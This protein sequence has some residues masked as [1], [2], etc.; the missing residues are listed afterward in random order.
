MFRAKNGTMIFVG[1]STGYIRVFDIQS[2]KQM[3]PLFEQSRQ[4]DKVLCI[5]ISE[6]GHYLLAGYKS[7]ALILWDAAKFKRAHTMN[8]VAAKGN[9][10]SEFSMVKILFV[11]D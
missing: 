6:D 3:K 10:V 1:N 2:Q 8:D 4:Q 5:D 11:T 9:A 7:G